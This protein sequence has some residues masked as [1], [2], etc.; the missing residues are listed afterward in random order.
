MRAL[1][2]L[3]IIAVIVGGV[4][5]ALDRIAVNM[6]EDEA[7]G[8]I[9]LQQGRAGSTE[10][11]IKGFP[12]LTQVAGKEL[13]EVGVT[14]TG[15]EA[16]ANGRPVRIS[17]MSAD[18][19]EV[20]LGDGYSSATASRAEGEARISY[21]DLTKAAQDGVTVAY[22]QNGKVKV[23]GSVEVLGRTVTRSVVS[24]VSLVGGTT[25]RVRADA[26]PGGGI[27]GIEELVRKKTDFDRQINGL[28]AGLKIEKVEARQD[29]VVFTVAG[30]DIVLAG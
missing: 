11:S 13:D 22:G 8:R 10:V 21:E 16:S 12:F 20:R 29:G 19:F 23:T 25:I 17:E 15:I 18:L 28:P 14:M 3:L 5:V 7:A 30:K 6:A 1:R 4:F 2:I 27:P 26:V 24:S 9:K